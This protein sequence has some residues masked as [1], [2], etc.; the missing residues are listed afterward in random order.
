MKNYKKIFLILWILPIMFINWKE[1][2]ISTIDNRELLSFREIYP[3]VQDFFDNLDELEPLLRDRIGFRN[4]MIFTHGNLYNLLFQ[5]LEHPLY[6][7]GEDGEVFFTFREEQDRQKENLEFVAFLE[8]A[9]QYLKDREIPFVVAFNPGKHLVYEE[10]IPHNI[11]VRPKEYEIF[12]KAM[13]S[14]NINFVNN[15]DYLRG[16]KD[17]TIYNKKFD[18]GHWTDRGA[19]YGITNILERFHE[20]D[21]NIEV[22][23]FN[24][25]TKEWVKE[26]YLPVSN[27]II[28]EKVEEFQGQGGFKNLDPEILNE[29][30]RETRTDEHYR[31]INIF[32]NKDLENGKRILI[33][34]GSF[35]NQKEFIYAPSFQEVVE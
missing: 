3:T 15:L 9:D 25:F 12:V 16:L 19:I 14:S 29:I 8:R 4:K 35:F 22:P 7:Y 33:F 13:E 27:I 5:K 21:P 24:E 2:A 28:N 30:R 10:K 11:L 31:Y 1:P 23:D 6:E 17:E 32:Q 18:V 34:R 20:M 26:K